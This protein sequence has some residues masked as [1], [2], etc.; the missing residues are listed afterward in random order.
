MSVRKRPSAGGI[1]NRVAPARREALRLDLIQCT[2]NTGLCQALQALYGAGELEQGLVFNLRKQ[3]TKAKKMHSDA[4]TPYGRVVQTLDIPS[5]SLPHWEICH[6]LAFIHYLCMLS[7]PFFEI[8]RSCLAASSGILQVIIYID[9][10][11]PGNA[12]RHDKGRTLQ[13][14]DWAFANW[15]PWLLARTGAWPVFGILRSKIAKEVVGEISCL[16]KLVL[17]TF[18]PAEGASFQVGIVICNQEKVSTYLKASFGGFLA[19]EKALKEIYDSK[20]ASGTP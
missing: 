19:D 10:I 20:G 14:L 3:L 16:M 2:T 6:P 17:Q 1:P 13:A 9:E 15:P 12:L 8:L 7:S 11:C 18:F 4:K 5:K